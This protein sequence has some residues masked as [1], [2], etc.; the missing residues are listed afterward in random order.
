MSVSL[1]T[2]I[3]TRAVDPDTHGSRR[4]K[5]SNQKR[6]SARKLVPVITASLFLKLSKFAQ[7]PLFLT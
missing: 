4:E 1:K 3:L 5:F 6:K 2:N 7:T